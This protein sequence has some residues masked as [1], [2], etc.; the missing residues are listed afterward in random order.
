M[1]PATIATSVLAILMPYVAKGAK[2]FIN[3]AG[4]AGYEKAKGMLQKIKAK[5]SGDQEVSST[6]ERFEEKPERYKPVLEDILKEK[7][8]QDPEMASQLAALLKEMGPTLH[9]IQEME[10]GKGVTGLA[11]GEVQSGKVTVDQKI[12]KAEDVTG[13]KIDRIG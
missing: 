8:A 3:I 10:E 2:E 11:A 5:W 6:I 12:K 7:L 4:E 13:A 1:D 9:I